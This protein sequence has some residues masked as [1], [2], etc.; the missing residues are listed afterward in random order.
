MTSE[1]EA[2]GRGETTRGRDPWPD[3]LTGGGDDPRPETPPLEEEPRTL[4]TARLRLLA[5]AVAVAVVVRTIWSV[6]EVR[7]GAESLTYAVSS[8]AF[9]IG[10]PAVLAWWL[11]RRAPAETAMGR[12]LTGTTAGLLLTAMVLGEGAICVALAAPLVY[13]VAWAVTAAWQRW[14]ERGRHLAVVALLLP[15]LPAWT[16]GVEEVHVVRDLPVPA[17]VAHAAI[18]EGPGLTGAER[19][20]LLTL[21]YPVPG[22][23]VRR[24]GGRTDQWE[25]RY[26]AGVSRFEVTRD[27]DAYRFVPIEDTAMR[28]WFAWETADLRVVATEAGSR[29]EL[30]L[31]FDPALGPDWYFGTVER[32]FMRA[33]GTHLLGALP[34]GGA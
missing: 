32:V 4:T 17:A 11:L 20:W 34:V 8:S 27:G 22:D 5:A 15:L 29:L 10:V 1:D 18:A 3:P 12:V 26:G 7:E 21:G 9:F 30:T 16:G 23:P 14:N 13:L 6:V 31:R 24:S 33:A 25:Y 28:R 19:P 2:R